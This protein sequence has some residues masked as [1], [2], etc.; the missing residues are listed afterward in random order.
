MI[1]WKMEVLFLPGKLV[2]AK[3]DNE[4]MHVKKPAD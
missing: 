4:N 3:Y 2:D 1:L